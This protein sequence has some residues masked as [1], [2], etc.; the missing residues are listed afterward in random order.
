MDACRRQRI[1]A[2]EVPVQLV[3]APPG[4]KAT[5][6]RPQRRHARGRGAQAPQED[7]QPETRSADD[8]CGSPALA[9][10]AAR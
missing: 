5:Q 1:E 2:R 4:R 8:Q 10:I 6:Y 3:E 9:D 7:S